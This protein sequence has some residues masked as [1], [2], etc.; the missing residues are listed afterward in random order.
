MGVVGGGA[1]VVERERRTGTGREGRETRRRTSEER[2]QSYK[3]LRWKRVSDD[4]SDLVRRDLLLVSQLRQRRSSSPILH[5]EQSPEQQPSPR[6]STKLLPPPPN[7]RPPGDQIFEKEV[8]EE[9][10]FE[11][12]RLVISEERTERRSE[13]G[14][15]SRKRVESTTFPRSFS[16]WS[17]PQALH[18]SSTSQGL[19]SK[20]ESCCW[21]SSDLARCATKSRG[22]GSGLRWRWW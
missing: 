21:G 18:L 17:H 6:E 8:V 1:A 16:S 5:Q 14:T 2:R 20:I 4:A 13:R 15:N 11:E 9:F 22:Q 12:S 10:P 3:L 7:R 19:P